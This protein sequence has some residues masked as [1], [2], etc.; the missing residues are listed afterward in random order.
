M[1]EVETGRFREDLYY[2]L[3][4]YPISI[5]SLRQ[6]PNDIPLLV[7][8]FIP[9][10]ARK[11]D[12]QLEEIAPSTLEM[13]QH[14]H[15]P[16]NV[17]ELQNVIERAVI[18][19]QGPTF[20]IP[21]GFLESTPAENTPQDHFE[22]GQAETTRLQDVEYQHILGILKRCEWQIDGK[23]GAAILLGIHPNTLRSRMKKL[24]IKR[25]S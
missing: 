7:N 9:H 8:A 16:G 11:H 25:L 4:V 10:Y 6:R 18:I 1:K 23:K 19:S 24:G 15:W 17:R 20:R 5:P 3:R 21:A 13:L 12:K 22:N 14:Y 2:R